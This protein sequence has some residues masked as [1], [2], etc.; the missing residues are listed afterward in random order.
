MRTISGSAIRKAMVDLRRAKRRRPPREGAAARPAGMTAATEDAC[1]ETK[2]S[3][4]ARLYPPSPEAAQSIVFAIESPPVVQRAIILVMIS[5][6]YICCAMLAGAGGAAPPRGGAR[7]RGG[8]GG[9]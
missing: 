8:G 5:C 4:Q 3:G 7:A 9:A 1:L 6:V 2:F